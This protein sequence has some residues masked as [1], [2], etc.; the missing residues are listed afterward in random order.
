[1]LNFERHLQVYELRDKQLLLLLFSF[2]FE[3]S[4]FLFKKKASLLPNPIGFLVSTY[5]VDIW[6]AKGL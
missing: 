2:P 6:K 3:I 5:H 1:M 4:F